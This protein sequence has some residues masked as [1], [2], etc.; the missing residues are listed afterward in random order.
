ML[1]DMKTWIPDR[2]LVERIES[3]IV[4]PKGARPLPEYTRNYQGV[5]V[6]NRQYVGAQLA[7]G[8]DRQIHLVDIFQ[9]DPRGNCEVVLFTFDLASNRIEDMECPNTR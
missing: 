1:P 7:L 3:Q 5:T 8:G 6:D 2:T 4:L 9:V